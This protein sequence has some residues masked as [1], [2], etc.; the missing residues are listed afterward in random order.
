[1]LKMLL[2][3]FL[4]LMVFTASANNSGSLLLRGTIPTVCSIAISP[5]SN[6]INLNLSSG[7]TGTKVGVVTETCNDPLGYIIQV[8]SL[9]AGKLQHSSIPAQFVSYQ[10]SYNNGSYVAPTGSAV[11]VKTISSLTQ[12]TVNSSDVKITLP[13]SPNLL[14]GIYSDTVTISIVA[15]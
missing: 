2:G 11:T 5:D 12:M 15:N 9:N 7:E 4:F 8:S 13:A 3:C 6:A 14:S 1:M 10:L